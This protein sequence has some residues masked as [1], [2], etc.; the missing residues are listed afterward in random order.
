MTTTYADRLAAAQ[1]KRKEL[2][3]LGLKLDCYSA[4]DDEG[5]NRACDGRDFAID[6]WYDKDTLN[7]VQDL[8]CDKVFDPYNKL[9]NLV[10]LQFNI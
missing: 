4:R 1:T 3:T 8:K 5:K 10:R 6:V 7:T 9:E 2:K